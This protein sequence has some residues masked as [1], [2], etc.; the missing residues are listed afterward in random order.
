MSPEQVTALPVGPAADVF[1]LGCVLAYAATGRS[2]FGEGPP[3]AITHRIVYERPDLSGVPGPLVKLIASCLEKDPDARPSLDHILDV[4]RPLSPKTK[5]P[6]VPAPVNPAASTTPV[7]PPNPANQVNHAD[8]GGTGDSPGRTLRV[9]FVEPPSPT[10][11]RGRRPLFA[12]GAVLAAGVLVAATL[13]ALNTGTSP[14]LALDGHGESVNGV[15]FSPDGKLVATASGDRLDLWNAQTGAHLHTLEGRSGLAVAFAPDGRLLAGPCPY[16]ICLYDVRSGR[17]VRTMPGHPEAIED[18]AFSRDGRLLASA[19]GDRI[20]RLW[21]PATGEH[22]KTLTGHLGNVH[23]VAFTPA[24]DALVTAGDVTVRRW[25]VVPGTMMTELYPKA[26]EEM[27]GAAFSPDGATYAAGAASGDAFIWDA[28]TN[29]LRFTLRGHAATV[30]DVAYSPDGSM[31]ATAGDDDFVR[32]WSTR[33]GD[34]L[35]EIEVSALPTHSVAFSPDGTMLITGG[36][37]E[38]ARLWRLDEVL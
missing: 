12:L 31:L 21:D 18:L 27:Y 10:A 22:L 14:A 5:P 28:E 20:V 11:K 34:L 29:G 26:N 32:L 19:S 7:P 1:S 38:T 3:W 15:A 37:D 6:E 9:T 36:Q 33:S 8:R 25:N 16:G 13:I 35:A 30:N 4:C 23:A 17:R 2:P 24:G